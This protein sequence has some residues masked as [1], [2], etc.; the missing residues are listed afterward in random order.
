MYTYTLYLL[1]IHLNTP[2]YEYLF[3]PVSPVFLI[4]SPSL[5]LS[6]ILS[7]SLS[8]FLSLYLSLS[9]SPFSLFFMQGPYFN[10]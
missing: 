3:V 5:T 6:L 10:V 7:L 4:L 9:L 8:F 2:Q 1:F